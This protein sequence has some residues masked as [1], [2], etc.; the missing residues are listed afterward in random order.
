M[1]IKS[2]N[3]LPFLRQYDKLLAVIVLIGLVISLFYLTNAGVARKSSEDKYINQ[4][5]QLQPSGKPLP[6]IGMEEYN[7]AVSAA[8]SPPLVSLS[9][10]QG[11][12]FLTPERRVTCIEIGCQKPIPYDATLCP[13]CG[14]TQP[15]PKDKDPELD[16]DG[17]G[18]SDKR[19]LE[20]GMNPTDPADAA[21]DSD[22]DG[23]TNLQEILAGTDMK[24]PKSHPSLL[25]L[26]RV[27]SIQ[28]LKI[29]FIFSGLNKM[30]D[31]MQMVFNTV[32]PRRTFWV[33]DG[34]L[35]GETGWIAVKAEQ[36]FEKR[37]NPLMPGNPKTVEVSTVVVK[38]KA[39][40]KEVT[41]I[42]NEGRKDTDVEATIVLPLDQTEYAA[43]EGGKFKVREETYRVVSIDKEASSVIVEN[44]STGEQKVI[45]KLD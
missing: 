25:T 39:D 1:T 22:G 40:N 16:S 2:I 6:A 13:F 23:F 33:N 32:E 41:M 9:G 42:I 7:S 24:D 30:P 45:T 5:A 37:E 43:V 12:G 27:K 21:A 31:G 36:K 10:N 18:I 14:K 15:V 11:A 3:E 35:I 4:L 38:R 26:L 8:K 20:L 34:A 17:D 44:E 29:P 19:E 28:S